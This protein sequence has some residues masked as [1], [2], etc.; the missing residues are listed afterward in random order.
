[1]GS[2]EQELQENVQDKAAN[3]FVRNSITELKI[4]AS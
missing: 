3:Y 2:N 4:A 1:L